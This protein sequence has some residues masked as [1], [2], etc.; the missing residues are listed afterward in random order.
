MNEAQ[1]TGVISFY[2]T[3]PINEE[4][5]LDKIAAQG[6]SLDAL[7]QGDLKDFDQ[8]HYGGTEV[9]DAL[10]DAAEIVS[11]HHVLDVCSGM[12]GP[13]RWL[14]Y[15]RKCKVTGLDFT[16]SRVE[17]ATRLTKRVQLDHLVDFV[18]GDATAMPLPSSCYD[19]C[20]LEKQFRSINRGAPG[21]RDAHGKYCLGGKLRRFAR[22][23]WL[24]CFGAR[25]F[26]HRLEGHSPQTSGN[27]SFVTRFNGRKIW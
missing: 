1:K 17:A 3:H 8:D 15:K 5:I 9:L 11:K 24:R 7:T 26:I 22:K 14:A 2:D 19:V 23:E 13:A 25:R 18:H 10:A 16:A 21:R 6:A 20:R 4:Q 27:V 12:G